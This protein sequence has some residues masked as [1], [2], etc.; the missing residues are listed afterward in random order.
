MATILVTGAQGFVGHAFCDQLDVREYLVK[1]IVRS[2]PSGSETA[3]GEFGPET[4]WNHALLGCDVVV[5]LAARVHMM[6]DVARDP[7]AEFRAVN[8]LATLNLARQAAKSG[9]SRFIYLSSVKV[10]GEAGAIS[11]KDQPA[12]LDAYAISKWEA[13]LGLGEIAAQTGMEMVILR[14]PLV[15]G[16]GVKANFLRLLKWVDHG[17]PLPFLSIEN[18]RSMLYLGNLVD[19]LMTCLEHPDVSGKTYLLSDGEDVSTPALIRLMAGA[20]GKPARLWPLSSRGLR[21]LGDLFGKTTEID[22][23]IG[24]LQVDSNAFHMDTGWVPPFTLQQGIRETI[25][26]YRGASD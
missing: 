15:Y 23:L 16:P 25:E 20:M 26:W 13:E 18:C 22:R 1:R 3:F 14:P 11:E 17:V 8:T 5:H 7:L 2:H 4:D 9:V 24:S 19:A 6:R 10:N 12:P 21:L